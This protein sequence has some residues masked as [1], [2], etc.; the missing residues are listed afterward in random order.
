[1]CQFKALDHFFNESS[2][3]KENQMRWFSDWD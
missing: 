1:M 2:A 3:K